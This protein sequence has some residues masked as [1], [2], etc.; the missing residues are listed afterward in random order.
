MGVLHNLICVNLHL[1]LC[2]SD[3]ALSV[4]RKAA[5]YMLEFAKEK[6]SRKQK[7][8]KLRIPSLSA[9]YF[10]SFLLRCV[11]CT[12][13]Y[14]VTQTELRA[15]LCTT[16]QPGENGLRLR[17]CSSGENLESRLQ[18]SSSSLHISSVWFQVEPRNSSRS[19]NRFSV[20]HVAFEKKDWIVA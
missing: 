2:V 8:V 11:P 18:E 1:H 5:F 13:S 10:H 4:I 7:H 16:S 3:V 9:A 17:V 6:N 12:L 19:L 15:L 14:S 20:F